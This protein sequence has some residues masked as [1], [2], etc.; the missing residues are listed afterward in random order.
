[1]AIIFMGHKINCHVKSIPEIAQHNNAVLFRR[2]SVFKVAC[3]ALYMNGLSNLLSQVGPE[4]RR[5]E[6]YMPPKS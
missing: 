2:I 5:E 4:T 6:R 3:L 1:M